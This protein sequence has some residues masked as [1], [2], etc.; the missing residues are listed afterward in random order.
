MGSCQISRVC[1]EHNSA[2]KDCA[3]PCRNRSPEL[4][5]SP[6][7]APS[8]EGVLVLALVWTSLA[9]WVHLERAPFSP[10]HCADCPSRVF[11]SPLAEPRL[12]GGLRILHL[13]EAGPG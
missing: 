7:S 8:M 10:L 1:V 3:K 4:F 13:A 9:L 5:S 12:A 2:C 6:A 11:F